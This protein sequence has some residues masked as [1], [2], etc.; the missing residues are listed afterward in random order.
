MN[1][2]VSICDWCLSKNQQLTYT[3]IGC[4]E[5]K[6]ELMLCQSCLKRKNN[7]AT[8]AEKIKEEKVYL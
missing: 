3:T 7:G 6:D 1:K 5:D 8:K 2:E 4:G